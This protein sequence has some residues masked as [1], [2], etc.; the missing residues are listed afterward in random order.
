MPARK[1]PRNNQE[2]VD[3][4]ISAVESQLGEMRIENQTEFSR[5][6]AKLDKTFATKDF[7]TSTYT[8]L[9]DRVALLEDDRK[10]LIRLIIGTVV[11]GIIGAYIGLK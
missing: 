5:L 8:Q 1:T 7:V 4:R 10:W 3:Y 6:H 9:S 11:L 2:F